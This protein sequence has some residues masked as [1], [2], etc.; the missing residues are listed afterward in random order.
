MRVAINGCGVAGPTLAW[1]LRHYGHEPVLLERATSPRTGGYLIDFWGTGYDVAERMGLLPALKQR[2]YKMQRLRSV[3]AHGWPTSTID[4]TV[5][6]EITDGR[7]FSIARSEL[8]A[9]ILKSCA[10][11]EMRFGTGIVGIEDRGTQLETAL[12]DGSRERFDLV[13]G[14]DGLH[15]KVRSI[16]FGPQSAFERRL[17]FHVAAFTLGGYQ[18]RDELA[19]VS[20]TVPGRYLARVS[21]R[22]NRTMFL[23]VFADSFLGSDAADA[24]EIRERLRDVYRNTGWESA[25][26]LS[27]IGEA[28]DLYMDRASQIRMPHWTRNRVALVGDAASAPSLLAGEG[29]SLA[30]TQARVLAGELARADGDVAAAF[31]GYEAQLKQFLVSKQD[32]ALRFT[33]YFAPQSWPGLVFRDVVSNIASVPLLAKWMFAS[34]FRDNLEL[35]DY[36]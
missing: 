5:F 10:G 6:D 21:L 35:P 11:I 12:A 23:M 28:D 25:A 26:I 1:W 22:E 27:R 8:S 34:T 19:A 29:T 17:G 33:G 36:G 20:H 32:A 7:Y 9:E 2:A 13:I 30:M 4:A 15:S 31:G 24:G 3:N 14:A 18:P 16:A